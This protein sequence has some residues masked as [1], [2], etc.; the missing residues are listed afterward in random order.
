MAR[1][2]GIATGSATVWM[3]AVC[4]VER[5]ALPRP[6]KA[7]TPLTLCSRQKSDGKRQIGTALRVSVCSLEAAPRMALCYRPSAERQIQT[8]D[9]TL[10]GTRHQIGLTGRPI[11]CSQAQLLCALCATVQ[12]GLVLRGLRQAMPRP[13]N[14]RRPT[15]VGRSIS[16]STL[17]GT[18]YPWGLPPASSRMCFACVLGAHRAVLMPN[19]RSHTVPILRGQSPAPLAA[20]ALNRCLSSYVEATI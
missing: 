15:V 6:R 3:G 9:S 5:R 12:C 10:P 8:G 19:W 1:I 7:S 16:A 20:R 11:R 4:L 17:F 14:I 13:R 18:A 2:C